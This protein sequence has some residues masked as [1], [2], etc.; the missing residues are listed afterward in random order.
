MATTTTTRINEWDTIH[1]NGPFPSQVMYE[2]TLAKNKGDKIK[3]YN[4]ASVEIQRLLDVCVRDGVGFRAMGSGWSLSNIA[5]HHERMHNNSAMNIHIPIQDKNLHPSTSFLSENLFMFQ[6]G[7]TI[8]EV[9]RHLANN[10]KSLKASGTNNGQTIV[11][12][13]STGVHGSAI[14]VGSVQDC[15]VGIHLIIGPGPN[16]LVYIERQSEPALSDAFAT[17]INC[18]V[19]RDDGLFNSAIVGLGSFGF[20]M[21]L[22]LEAEDQYLL[23]RYVRKINKIDALQ[24]ATSF[25]FAQS[26]FKIPIEVDSNGEGKRPYHY[27]LYVNPYNENEDFVVEIIYKHPYDTDYPDPRPNVK[28]FL[29]SDLP[30][31]IANIAAKY[32]RLIPA[33]INALK[34]NIFPE[35]DKDTTG[36]IGQLFSDGVAEGKVFAWAFG[37]KQE[38]TVRSL[39]LFNLIVNRLGPVPGAIGIRF[40]KA[41]RATLAFTQ[42]PVTCV[43]EMDG[44]QWQ[45]N[46]NMRT[47]Q[48]IE[49]AIIRDF[50]KEGIEFS[51]HWGK[52][53]DWGYPGLLN[54]MYKSKVDT[55][56]EHRKQLLSPVMQKVFSNNFTET[57][58]LTDS[59]NILPQPVIV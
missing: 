15:I 29:F 25:T 54:Y 50:I 23:K 19:I 26:N 16:D 31:L 51:W 4:D 46:A 44:L 28:A 14:D 17:S 6:C 7:N 39:N 21:G 57:A 34:A 52:N 56:K 35:L 24:L 27:K 38:D 41:A 30:G 9:S 45:G 47:M 59:A 32:K 18:R 48:E 3:R 43:L 12:A 37:V 58:G 49:T 42:F 20:V 33:I 22:V 5:H 10:G 2:T 40:V 1:Q 53:A 55:W 13:V 36:T 11:G 8:K